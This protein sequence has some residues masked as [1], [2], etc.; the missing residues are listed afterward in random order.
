[1][2]SIAFSTSI[3]RPLKIS[4]LILVCPLLSAAD[5]KS[6]LRVFLKQNCKKFF[7]V[8]VTE[9]RIG[10]SQS[11]HFTVANEIPAR[12]ARRYLDRLPTAAETH[13]REKVGNSV[14]RLSAADG[15]S[16]I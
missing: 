16:G 4:R 15:F 5:V 1:M 2:F 3:R 7:N 12:M 11:F 9:S 13:A 14:F 10:A 8:I 6:F